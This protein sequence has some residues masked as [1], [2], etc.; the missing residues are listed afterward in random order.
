M[1]SLG[2]TTS[3][4]ACLVNLPCRPSASLLRKATPCYFLQ[5]SLTQRLWLHK[6]FRSSEPCSSSPSCRKDPLLALAAAAAAVGPVVAVMLRWQQ[7]QQGVEDPGAVQVVQWGQVLVKGLGREG[8]DL[9]P[10]GS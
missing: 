6:P 4:L 9:A 3:N 8:R 2:N 7:Q 10:A 5:V 1:R